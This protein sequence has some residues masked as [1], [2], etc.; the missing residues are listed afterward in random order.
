DEIKSLPITD[1][2]AEDIYYYRTYIDFFN[3]VYDLR[4]IENIDQVTFNKIK[5]LIM[6]HPYTEY[7][8][9]AQ[10]RDKI[11]YLLRG[12]ASEEGSSELAA[13]LWEDLLISPVNIN[14]AN[15]HVL[16]NMP[17]VS[18][19]D[20]RAILMQRKLGNFS[21]YR[22]MRKAPGLSHYGATKLKH[23]VIYQT[24]ERKNKWFFNYRFKFNN[25][26]F[27]DE[28][29]EVLLES[30]LPDSTN[31]KF[32][33]WGRYHLDNAEPEISHKLRARMEDWIDLEFGGLLF[34]KKGENRNL[35]LF[36]SENSLS[37][38]LSENSKLSVALNLKPINTRLILGNFRAT[39][40]QGLV[41]ENTD[42]FDR[43]RTGFGYTKRVI[44]VFPDISSTNEFALK[45]SAIEFNNNFLNASFFYSDDKKDAVIWDSNHNDSLDV[46]DDLFYYI[47]ST[48]RFTN[49]QLE[50]DEAYFNP[51]RENLQPYPLPKILMA[52]RRDVLRET[53]TGTHIEVSPL[54]GTHFGITAYEALYDRYFNIAPYD[55]LGEYLI[56]SDYYY[57]KLK[58]TD[59]EISSLYSTKTNTYRRNYRRVYGF[60]WQTTLNNL[61]IQGE[62][63]EL[64]VDGKP[65]QLGDDPSAMVLSGY[66]NFENLNFL[67]LYRNYD[68]DFDNPYARPFAEHERFDGTILKKQYYLKN[69]LV[70]EV[71]YN[72][73]W[74]QPEQG[75]YIESRYKFHR[76]L[77]LTKAYLDM[78]K[79]KSDGRISVRFQAEL[80]Y[81]PIYQVSIRLKQKLQ[82]NRSE[83]T[84]ARS[85][86]KTS[87]T[88]L[89]LITYLTNR[90]KLLLSYFYAQTWM[91]PYPYL[92]DSAVPGDT[93]VP[94]A[95]VLNQGNCIEAGYIHNFN[96]NFRIEGSFLFWKAHHGN[97]WDWEDMEIDFMGNE[98]MK[99]WFTIY[100]RISNHLA[101][102][103]K[104]KVKHYED[105]ELY[106]RKYNEP[107]EGQNYIPQTKHEESSIRLQIDWNF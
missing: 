11:Y 71:Y 91:V 72:S 63:A 61:S 23:Y 28:L 77:T 75:I 99:Y 80:D 62:Y 34:F 38:A 44:G 30:F 70:S 12:F 105:K 31:N 95:N 17:I 82:T 33:M 51:Y 45:G 47:I 4:E 74:S 103:F 21:D 54:I 87:E 98:G 13:S 29:K 100:D 25:S 22:S 2:Q 49:E 42:Y 60:D 46:E 40:G 5:P 78:W 104:Y 65:L 58:M 64:E 8:E 93:I 3:S 6:V 16:M 7:D 96:E 85:V 20:V 107:V 81:R 56:Y 88:T 94:T 10:R 1:K 53:I 69:S 106:L 89:K 24:P 86:S 36:L 39:Y 14:N 48:P 18:P 90:D 73:P 59:S 83:D 41:M 19:S 35:N 37:K 79:R 50:S 67:I 66:L 27:S 26:P 15:F 43:R 68:L 76:Q 55:S 9:V 52:P 97:V 32:S 84:S 57:K 92:T 102:S 101:I